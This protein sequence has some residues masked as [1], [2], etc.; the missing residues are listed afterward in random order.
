[1][2]YELTSSELT[3]SELT[4]S[5]FLGQTESDAYEPTVQQH[6]WAQK[7]KQINKDHCRAVH[8]TAKNSKSSQTPDRS[9]K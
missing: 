7:L 8:L 3:S 6:R 1:M 9:E 4:S 2:R 5:E